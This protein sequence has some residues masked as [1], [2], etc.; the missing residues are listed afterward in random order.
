MIYKVHAGFL[1]PRETFSLPH[2]GGT[3]SCIGSAVK[4]GACGVSIY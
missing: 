2:N 3:K 4:S 1:D